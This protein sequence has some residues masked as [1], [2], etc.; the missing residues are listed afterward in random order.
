M[1]AR[2]AYHHPP[3]RSRWPWASAR[4]IA[5]DAP[6]K[7]R[8][9]GKLPRC[10]GP[11]VSCAIVMGLSVGRVAANLALSRSGTTIAT[12]PA[13]HACDR[14]ELP[15]GWHYGARSHRIALLL[16]S[17]SRRQWV[18][19]GHSRS[20]VVVRAALVRLVSEVGVQASWR[21]VCT[22]PMDHRGSHH[23]GLRALPPDA[24]APV[25]IRVPSRSAYTRG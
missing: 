20:S 16:W 9:C 7:T 10:V 19:G 4:L 17:D 11:L 24:A 12:E 3:D 14:F 2:R 25:V 1:P 5:C 22:V 18:G 13:Q 23:K 21:A 6:M 8:D 15:R